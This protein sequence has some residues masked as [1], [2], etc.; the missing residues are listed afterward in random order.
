MMVEGESCEIPPM[1]IH[2][3][4]ALTDSD[5]VEW[6]SPELYDLVRLEDEYGRLDEY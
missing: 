5:I 3:I 4:E 2:R 1:T 6:S